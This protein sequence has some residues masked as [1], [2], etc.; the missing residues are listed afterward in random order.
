MAQIWGQSDLLAIFSIFANFGTLCVFLMG[1]TCLVR[2]EKYMVVILI[3]I[4]I[5]IIFVSV[6]FELY[7]V[8]GAMR[9]PFMST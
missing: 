7:L 1:F 6:Y 4:Y 9:K 8:L 5:Y 3:Y 2:I